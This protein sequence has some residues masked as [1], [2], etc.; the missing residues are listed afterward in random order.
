M[1]NKELKDF[2]KR[3][4]KDFLTSNYIDCSQCYRNNNGDDLR[5]VD[6]FL[7]FLELKC[8]VGEIT[9]DKGEDAQVSD[10]D[11]NKLKSYLAERWGVIKKTSLAYTSDPGAFG[12]II[13]ERLARAITNTLP[14]TNKPHPFQLLI[15]TVDGSIKEDVTLSQCVLSDD[16]KTLIFPS[17]HLKPN[18]LSRTFWGSYRLYETTGVVQTFETPFSKTEQRRI[19]HHS[20]ASQ[21]LFK[22][23][24]R[25]NKIDQEKDKLTFDIAQKEIEIASA[26]LTSHKASPK[27]KRCYTYRDLKMIQSYCYLRLQRLDAKLIGDKLNVVKDSNLPIAQSV[28]TYLTW[29]VPKTQRMNQVCSWFG[30]SPNVQ[31]KPKELGEQFFKG[32]DE[33]IFQGLVPPKVSKK[34]DLEVSKSLLI[35]LFRKAERRNLFILSFDFAVHFGKYQSGKHVVPVRKIVKFLRKCVFSDQEINKLNQ[36][37]LGFLLH[38]LGSDDERLTLI[39]YLAKNRR[40]EDHIAIPLFEFFSDRDDQFL[41]RLYKALFPWEKYKHLQEA[42]TLHQ[43]SNDELRFRFITSCFE[44]AKYKRFMCSYLHLMRCLKSF[45]GESKE[46][47]KIKLIEWMHDINAL[48]KVFTK[49]ELEEYAK[50]EPALDSSGTFALAKVLKFLPDHYRPVML[51]HLKEKRRLSFAGFLRGSVWVVKGVFIGIVKFS[52][53]LISATSSV[54]VL[55]FLSVLFQMVHSIGQMHAYNVK[56]FNGKA[57]SIHRGVQ[58]A[59]ILPHILAR[60]IFIP[61]E[62][63]W[64]LVMKVIMLFIRQVLI[65][66]ISTT[67][68]KES[69]YSLTRWEG[70]QGRPSTG[71]A[72]ALMSSFMH[73]NAVVRDE[74]H[75]RYQLLKDAFYFEIKDVF[76]LAAIVGFIVGITAMVCVLSGIGLPVLSAVQTFIL[77]HTGINILLPAIPLGLNVLGLASVAAFIGTLVIE[78]GVTLLTT[79]LWVVGYGIQRFTDF[80]MGRKSDLS[81]T[82]FT[83]SYRNLS[84]HQKKTIT[85]NSN[86]GLYSSLPY[87]K[88]PSFLETRVVEDPLQKNESTVPKLPIGQPNG[89]T[90]AQNPTVGLHFTDLSPTQV[91]DLT[92][93]MTQL[94]NTPPLF[95][96]LALHSFSPSDP[97]AE[98]NV[99]DMLLT[100]SAA[101]I[102][103]ILVNLEGTFE[104]EGFNF[105][106]IDGN[107]VNNLL[108]TVN[109]LQQIQTLPAPAPAATL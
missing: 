14:I 89:V 101:L 46:H 4:D 26:Q 55:P 63:A 107:V 108:T 74:K 54:F 35:E 80:V 84:P 6:A 21:R 41:A 34:K 68:E 99:K 44:S 2:V 32:R 109:Q 3:V 95:A 17:D 98:E 51:V 61:F 19:I 53:Y 79:A 67:R 29:L 59:L 38:Q 103:F 86:I 8:L 9:K 72:E 25:L 90:V 40:L 102:N 7:T 85:F 5:I 104:N 97:L 42:N 20:M 93:A 10:Q 70:L 64:L 92:Q 33:F 31:N 76:I 75:G 39:T 18:N 88:G 105:T 62:S 58:I 1:N 48:R 50:V 77:A 60:I 96:A 24:V 73:L 49:K 106:V 65:F 52:D 15:P 13:C 12:N 91:S 82:E 30:I 81:L 71:I 36:R 45:K 47:Y 66:P 69:T 56:L 57:L 43:F 87:N 22:A 23:C 16:E 100:G 37:Q 28:L 78:A 94:Q 27:R 83:P 11:I